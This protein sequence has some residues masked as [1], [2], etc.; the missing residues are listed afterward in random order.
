[1]TELANVRGE[2]GGT[3]SV[4]VA[5]GGGG[6]FGIA[7]HLAVLAALDE[8]HDLDLRRRSLLGLSAGAW[9]AAAYVTRTPLVRLQEAWAWGRENTPPRRLVRGGPLAERAFGDARDEHVS[10]VAWRPTGGRSVLSGRELRLADLVAA[11]SSPLGAAVGHRID[12]VAY[13]DAGTVANTSADLAPAADVLLVL[14]PLAVGV[15]GLQGQIWE[16]RLKREVRRWRGQHQR[17]VVVVR[18][19]ASAV[20]AGGERWRQVMSMTYAPQVEQATRDGLY[21]L[22]PEIAE[23]LR[24]GFVP[25]R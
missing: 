1:M 23:R 17:Q 12:G 18:P 8:E 13:Y 4:S 22:M 20:R 2:Q 25:E 16:R 24:G 15:L 10:A 9:A 6:A 21:D 14:A 3:R 7:F 5:L 19:P 11:S